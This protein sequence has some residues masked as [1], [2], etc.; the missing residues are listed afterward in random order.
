M[1]DKDIINLL[2]ED[3]ADIESTPEKKENLADSSN[4]SDEEVRNLADDIELE[5]KY[6]DSSVK[7]ALYGAARGVTFGGSDYLLKKTGYETEESLRETQERQETA[8]TLGE[9]GGVLGATFATG[10]LRGLGTGVQVA[11][12]AGTAVEKAMLASLAKK[13]SAGLIAKG[14]SKSAGLAIE[15]TFYSSGHVLSE[16]EL[17]RADFN[18]E[19]LITAAKDAAIFGAVIGTGAATFSHMV[20]KIKNGKAVGWTKEKFKAKP[21]KDL[22]EAGLKAFGVGDNKIVKI[23]SKM[24]KE[25]DN[26]TNY[27]TEDLQANKSMN[28]KDYH[29]KN[30]KVMD[31]TV[32]ELDN[33]YTELDEVLRAGDETG[34][35]FLGSSNKEVEEELLNKIDEYINKN[36]FETVNGEKVFRTVESKAQYEYALKQKQNI[37]EL[38]GTNTLRDLQAKQLYADDIFNKSSDEKNYKIFQIEQNIE[39]AKKFKEIPKHKTDLIRLKNNKT[40]IKNAVKSKVVKIDG[41]ILTLKHSIN[42]KISTEVKE[43]IKSKILKLQKRKESLKQKLA[44]KVS[45]FDNEIYKKTKIIKEAPKVKEVSHYQAQLKKAQK[46]LDEFEKAHMSKSEKNILKIAELEENA[47]KAV[48]ATK[49]RRLRNDWK[50]QIRWL[51]TEGIGF[52]EEAARNAYFALNDIIANLAESVHSVN[53]DISNRLLK[54]NLKFSTGKMLS[55]QLEI[56]SMKDSNITDGL[57]KFGLGTALKHGAVGGPIGF[58]LQFRGMNTVLKGF[59]DSHII[60]KLSFLREVEKANKKTKS[61]TTSSIKKFFQEKTPSVKKAKPATLNMLMKSEL[62]K[63]VNEEKQTSKAPKTKQ[64]A[65]KNI[66]E[67]LSKAVSNPEK[68]MEDSSTT[69][70]DFS[71]AAP[72]TQQA[73]SAQVLSTIQ[74][75]H[76]VLPKNSTMTNNMLVK[77]DWEPSTLELAKFERILNTVQNPLSILDDLESGTL[78]RESVEAVRVL[79]PRLYEQ[80]QDQVMTQISNAKETIPYQKRL[81]LGIL[82]DI[83]SD[84]ALHPANIAGLQELHN[85]AKTSQAG[86]QSSFTASKAE[87]LDLAESAQTTVEKSERR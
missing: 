2:Q 23:K 65:F 11:A 72:E 69:L 3:N 13:G 54:N 6:G 4:L 34:S 1:S 15:G 86:G 24:K 20:P 60:D 56:M 79:N 9:V 17:G 40:A 36:V 21:A 67:N 28:N 77:R 46:E 5:E 41:E 32:K 10:G 16:H 37:S 47:H 38:F 45:K 87:K 44:Q 74:Y 80:I 50:S 18:A 53:G 35:P 14:L 48:D 42:P 7:A 30:A 66:T 59:H 76:S 62:S 33:I 85:E 39:K 61:K 83:D 73:V 75:L 81:L 63:E 43:V 58:I 22:N 82:L 12:K 52:K 84:A 55:E 78:T 26:I 68:L 27:I 25:Y 57:L 64:E 49:I 8:S 71:D 29:L 31:D 70:H 19:N 51:K